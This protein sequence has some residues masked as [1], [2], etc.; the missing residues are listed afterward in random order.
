MSSEKGNMKDIIDNP[1]PPVKAL[2]IH[3]KDSGIPKAN[4]AELRCTTLSAT[5]STCGCNM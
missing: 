5:A 2:Q 3:A 1:I 4:H